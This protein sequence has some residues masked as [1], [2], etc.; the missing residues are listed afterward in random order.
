MAGKDKYGRHLLQIISLSAIIT[1]LIP[2][3][4]NQVPGVKYIVIGRRRHTW[5]LK[6][7]SLDEIFSQI[8]IYVDY[9]SCSWGSS[10]RRM[11]PNHKKKSKEDAGLITYS[12]FTIPPHAFSDSV[13]RYQ[14]RSRPF[15]TDSPVATS[16]L[17][18]PYRLPLTQPTSLCIN[19]SWHFETSATLY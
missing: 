16:H 12:L 2:Q 14:Q 8:P 17:P 1:L 7:G 6:N 18:C 15:E 5:T 10:L 11:L 3:V 9:S 13:S 19:I 4:V